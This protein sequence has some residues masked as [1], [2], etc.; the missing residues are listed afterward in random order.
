MG[1]LKN[2]KLRLYKFE[3]AIVLT[4]IVLL[5]IGNIVENSQTKNVDSVG[6]EDFAQPAKE[7]VSMSYSEKYE[8][9]AERV[10]K[11][12][13]GVKNVTVA[14]YVKNQGSK[15]P[16]RNENNDMTVIAESNGEN[17]AEENRDVKEGNVVVIKDS[18]G[19]EQVVMLS[20]IAPEI[21]GI[22]VCVEGGVSKILEEK[23]LKTLMA[24]YGI[25]PA[26]IS[27]TG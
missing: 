9:Q 25:S 26:K 10:L 12:I 11:G 17:H 23:I 13:E 15:I 19:N 2:V 27:I 3:V 1:I 20:E 4:G 6:Q 21:E 22:A 14:V 16:A 24:L 18:Q 5:L 7:T 8:A